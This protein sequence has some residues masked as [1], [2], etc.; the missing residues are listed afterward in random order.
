M[1]RELMAIRTS[2]MMTLRSLMSIRES[3]W[4]QITKI[5]ITTSKNINHHF[6]YDIK[7][8]EVNLFRSMKVPAG[9][10][11]NTRNMKRWKLKNWFTQ[12]RSSNIPISAPIL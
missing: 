10:K 9:K 3:K 1:F 12:V 5:T 11:Y 7:K 8:K 6:T 2:Q 4:R